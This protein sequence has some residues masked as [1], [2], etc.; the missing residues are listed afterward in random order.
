MDVTAPNLAAEFKRAAS[1]V[2]MSM[3]NNGTS[4]KVQLGLSNQPEKE[5]VENMVSVYESLLDRF[6]GKFDNVRSLTI[7]FGTKNWVVPVY[8]SCGK[9]RHNIFSYN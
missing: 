9:T 1:T 6:P 2:L 4:Y 7:R 5:I 8:V 3:T